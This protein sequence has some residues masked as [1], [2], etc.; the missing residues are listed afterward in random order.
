MKKSK[1]II[2]MVIIILVIVT[3][4]IV[5][6]FSKKKDNNTSVQDDNIQAVIYYTFDDK[7]KMPL[8]EDSTFSK[9]TKVFW[10]DECSGIIK[11]DGQELSRANNTQLTEHGKYE[12]T[13]NSPSGSSTITK[14][15]II[16]KKPPE[17][18]VKKNQSGTYTIK[19]ADTND[20]G[21][22]KLTRLDLN[23]SKTLSETDL[24]E[25]GL[26]PTIDVKQKGYYVLEVADKY[27]NLYTDT[28]EFS[29]E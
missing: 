13:V 21:M 20:V 26:K 4:I 15:I 9:N 10:Q 22:A 28:T 7:A 18:E 1:L 14:T 16:D 17:V 27:G 3:I 23:S 19:F 2:F 25:G 8:A 11:K 5:K 29:I 12:I 24:L 6:N